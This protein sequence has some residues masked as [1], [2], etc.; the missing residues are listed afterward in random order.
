MYK[1]F[2]NNLPLVLASES[3]EASEIPALKIV[4]CTSP[5]IA[6]ATVEAYKSG[7]IEVPVALIHPDVA[8][9]FGWCFRDFKR[10]EAAGGVIFN[11][12]GKILFIYRNDKWDLPKG[13]LDKGEDKDAAALREVEEECGIRG[14]VLEKEIPSTWHCYEH[15]G[16]WVIKITYWY[17]MRYAG[18][19]TPVPQEEEGITKIEWRNPDNLEDIRKNTFPSIIDCLTNALS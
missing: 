14:H 18:S 8:L 9:L 19:D 2:I 15:K 16:Q 17:I 6:S 12:K 1:V 11:P 3:S 5:E 13:K 7:G 4:D 10:I